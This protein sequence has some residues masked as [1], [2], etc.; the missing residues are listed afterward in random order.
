MLII[1]H[2][3]MFVALLRIKQTVTIEQHKIKSHL[4]TFWTFP[5]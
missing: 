1:N 4:K 5:K 2:I 3:K